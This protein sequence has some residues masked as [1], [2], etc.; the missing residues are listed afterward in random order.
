MY[1]H[2]IHNLTLPF[3][4]IYPDGRGLASHI[5]V[6]TQ[7]QWIA[8][9]LFRYCW[10]HHSRS[11]REDSQIMYLQ[12]MKSSSVCNRMC[13]PSTRNTT[14]YPRGIKK[15]ATKGDNLLIIKIVQR[16]WEVSWQ[17]AN[18]IETYKSSSNLLATRT[19]SIFLDKQKKQFI[20]WPISFI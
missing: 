19:S 4:S 8:S 2:T 13:Y 7:L 17:I 6:Q 1:S 12:S 18:I 14:F 3:Q 20:R 15:I 16:L 11:R 10:Y 9:F 5:L